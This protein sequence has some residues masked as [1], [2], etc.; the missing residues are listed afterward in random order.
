MNEQQSTRPTPWLALGCVVT[1]CQL[2]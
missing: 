1:A 2:Q